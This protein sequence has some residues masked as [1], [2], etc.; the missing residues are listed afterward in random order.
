MAMEAMSIIDRIEAQQDAGSTEVV[1]T[2]AEAVDVAARLH[3]Q[4][5]EPGRCS[6]GTKAW[7]SEA[8]RW[9]RDAR[10]ILARLD[11]VRADA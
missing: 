3:R 10:L 6:C 8:D 5:A 1:L 11:A 2:R 4:A 9:Y 7:C